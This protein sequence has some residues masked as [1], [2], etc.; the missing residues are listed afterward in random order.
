[1][2]PAPR[3]APRRSAS[4]RR[5][6]SVAAVA[7][8]C[9]FTLSL[10][11]PAAGAED[12]NRV[13]LR[14]NDRIV[15]LY[16]YRERLAERRGAIV[17]SQLPPEERKI[18][19]DNSASEVL[20]DLLDESLL[21]GRGDQLAIEVSSEELEEGMAHARRNFGVEDPAEFVRSLEASGVTEGEFRQRV[22]E[23]LI[24][25]QVLGTEVTARIRIDDEDLRRYYREHEAEFRIPAQNQLREIVVLEK[26][27][28]AAA[29]LQRIAAT[30]RGELAAGKTLE[31]VVAAAP[32]GALSGVID[33]G[34]VK[35]GELD[36]DLAAAVAAVAVGSYSEPVR[37]RGGFHILQ[38]VAKEESRLRPFEE[39]E[40]NLRSAERQ[41]RFRDALE[42]Y[43]KDLEKQAYIVASPPPEAANFRREVASA[44]TDEWQAL[45][46]V[47]PAA[48]PAEE[49]PAAEAPPGR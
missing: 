8:T 11:L 23:N 22:R 40:A 2:P 17:R 41:R 37:G 5:P 28:I 12:L 49:K 4:A 38:L 47:A 20:R 45:G 26:P 35:E 16:D 24:Y 19:L 18:A 30:V 13:V 46:A 48:P 27:T 15:T 25:Q 29:E 7:L 32:E 36:V 6:D 3:T 43:M 10:G 44:P 31:E 39:V 42:G 14:V 21:L 34:W 9:L 33:L 1:M